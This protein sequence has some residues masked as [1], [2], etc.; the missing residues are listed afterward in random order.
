MMVPFSIQANEAPVAVD[1]AYTTFQGQQIKVGSDT[2][3][4]TYDTDSDGFN[5]VKDAL[6]TNNANYIQGSWGNTLGQIGGGL[7]VKSGPT[8]RNG[9]PIGET[10]GTWDRIITLPEKTSLSLHV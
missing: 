6:G 1:D 2:L 8:H 10:S 5:L 3:N 9:M 7:Y 4:S